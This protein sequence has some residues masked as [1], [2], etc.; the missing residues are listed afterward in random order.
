M[1]RWQF[2][3]RQ[4]RL[5]NSAAQLDF[6]PC[7]SRAAS[8]I[9]SLSWS[10]ASRMYSRPL[11]KRWVSEWVSETERQTDK[12]K[13][14][15]TDT[16]VC[17]E[18]DGRKLARI[19][20]LRHTDTF[21]KT[22]IQRWTQR[23][24]DGYTH[25]QIV[26]LTRLFQ[27]S[28][29]FLGWVLPFSEVIDWNRAAIWAD[30]RLIFQVPSIGRRFVHLFILICIKAYKSLQVGRI[31]SISRGRM[32]GHT[33]FGRSTILCNAAEGL[34]GWAVPRHHRWSSL[35]PSVRSLT[36]NR[37]LAMRRQT[38]FLWSA[39]FASVEKIALTTI[40]TVKDRIFRQTAHQ[41]HH[42]NMRPGQYWVV[43]CLW[44][45]N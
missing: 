44:V 2:A 39:Y 22:D 35:P 29:I 8:W 12:V 38:L 43:I 36:L 16:N 4:I 24:A 5:S 7:A 25:S 21:M 32:D 37:I 31:M 17:T 20:W 14:K 1:R 6:L 9:L 34:T 23:N 45:C 15:E 18:A 13:H 3:V 26:S 27:Y 42:W 41:K 40:E 33:L 11:V 30:E 10:P 28:W 19:D